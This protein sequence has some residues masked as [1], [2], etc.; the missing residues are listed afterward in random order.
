MTSARRLIGYNL[1]SGIVLGVVGWYV[2]WYG[3]PPVVGESLDYF[4]DIDYNDLSLSSPTSA[5]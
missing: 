3:G 4:G 5:A 1:L 2:G